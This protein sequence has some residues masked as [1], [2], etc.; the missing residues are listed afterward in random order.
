MDQNEETLKKVIAYFN[1]NKERLKQENPELYAET[2]RILQLQKEQQG[3]SESVFPGALA[4]VGET[5]AFG[6]PDEVSGAI[7]SVLPYPYG[8]AARPGEQSN[9]TLADRY[10]IARDS[11]REQSQAFAQQNPG[12]S[13]GANLVGGIASGGGFGGALAKTPAIAQSLRQMGPGQRY[14]G[15]VGLG[16]AAGG[17]GGYGSSARTGSEA[18]DD[19]LT[20]AKW[21]AGLTA[22]LTP[23]VAAGMGVLGAVA[24]PLRDMYQLARNPRARFLS[25]VQSRIENDRMSLDDFR[26]SMN[27]LGP[28]AMPFESAGPNLESYSRMLSMGEGG[29]RTAADANLNLRNQGAATRALQSIKDIVGEDINVEEKIRA[30]GRQQSEVAREIGY[31]RVL[32]EWDVE[33]S[34]ALEKLMDGPTMQAALQGAK[35]LIRDDI[36]LG[37]ADRSVDMFFKTTKDGDVFMP[38]GM[39]QGEIAT[40]PTLRAWDYVKRALYDIESANIDEFGKLNEAGR[41][42]RQFR[43]KLMEEIDSPEYKKIREAYAGPSAVKD[44]MELGRKIFNNADYERLKIIYDGLESPAQQEAFKLGAARAIAGKLWNR[45]PSDMIVKLSDHDMRRIVAVFGRDDATDIIKNFERELL[46]KRN[47]NEILHG[48]RTYENAAEKQAAA[49][50]QGLANLLSGRV[51]SGARDMLGAGSSVMDGQMRDYGEVL[52]SSDPQ[53][54]ANL[55]R[56]LQRRNLFGD[57]RGRGNAGQFYG[58]LLGTSSALSSDSPYSARGLLGRTL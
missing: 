40:R 4:Q 52:F 56:E 1:E 46:F 7:Q 11:A 49:E 30:L 32:N 17:V 24:Q 47:A 13:L 23:A 27:E 14:L 35:R 53:A 48:S 58:G 54:K 34:P 55:L 20:G 8:L 38:F 26:A 29:A 51:L 44:A 22:A 9:D 33:L 50:R 31:D 18:A 39:G 41:K 6:L 10:R 5:A 28:E 45:N 57:F 15:G 37:E 25:D 21:G 19:A 3:R 16:G 36:A 42:A 2:L 12:I 43:K